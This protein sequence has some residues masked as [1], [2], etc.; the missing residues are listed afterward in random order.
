MSRN[1]PA[2]FV[3]GCLRHLLDHPDDLPAFQDLWPELCSEGTAWSAA[4]AA[5]PYI[6]EIADKL[7]PAQRFEHVY[8]V[9]YVAA[10][11]CSDQGESFR[12]Q[13]YLEGGYR[14][15]LQKGLVL[16]TETLLCAHDTIQTRYLLASTAALKGHPAL[17]RTIEMLDSGCPH[18][19]KP[20]LEAE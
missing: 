7:S 5:A 9:G 3:P 15:A 6:V 8:F 2:G 10:C 13:P 19:G 4:Y 17:G 14:E 20:L 16:L 18:C 11:E 12:L 1:G